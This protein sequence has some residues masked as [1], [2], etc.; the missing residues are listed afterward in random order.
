MT[1]I[2]EFQL[3]EGHFWIPEGEDV[4]VSWPVSQSLYGLWFEGEVTVTVTSEG[5]LQFTL[6]HKKKWES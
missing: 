1:A 2:G 5:K 3:P 4:E 6:T